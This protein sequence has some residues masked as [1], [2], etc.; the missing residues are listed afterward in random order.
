M[1]INTL[2]TGIAGFA[3]S[4]LAE[5]LLEKGHKVYGFLA[6][7]EKTAN[8]RHLLNDINLERFDILKLNRLS[9]FV[10][11]AKPDY[12]FHL[13]AFASVGQS[14][15]NERLVY[16]INFSGTLN[17]I[18]SV[19]SL[20]KKI[21]KLVFI[22]SSDVYG[23]FEPESKTLRESQSF[24]PQSPYAISKASGEYLML[25]HFKKNSLPAVRVR[26]F[27]HT[28]PRQSN[29]YAVPSFCRQ[30]AEIEAG[31]KKPVISVG[32]L[33]AKRDLSDVRDI[34]WG[35]YLSAIKG[36]PGD[37]YQLCSGKSVAIKT[38]LDKLLKC[39]ACDIKV[40]VDKSRFRKTDIP[41]LRGCNK[42][43]KLKLGWHLE[44]S[45]DRTLNDTLQY[46]RDK[47]KR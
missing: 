33:S 37:V 12:L 18:D 14:F 23:K 13:A 22:S 1:K 24:N 16:D 28:G 3:G 30:I 36:E 47:R 4:Y 20:N 11:L 6:P 31:A 26:A 21:K 40:R 17:L 41:V 46:W 25:Y 35:Y 43:A 5:I 27:N 45:L 39:S 9:R 8:L 19:L 34:V 29:N 42:Y 44:Y 2:V 15:D 32:D 10:K 7:G 38:V